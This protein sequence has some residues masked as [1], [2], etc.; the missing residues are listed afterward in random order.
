MK[1]IK[2]ILPVK[3]RAVIGSR[4]AVI[5]STI[6]APAIITPIKSM[7]RSDRSAGSGVTAMAKQRLGG[8]DRTCG[9]AEQRAAP[10]RLPRFNP[11]LIVD[12][13]ARGRGVAG[14]LFD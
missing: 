14:R 11:D 6:A 2:P 7:V 1:A 8:C 10:R 13:I 3:C 9:N 12:V 4:L 5:A